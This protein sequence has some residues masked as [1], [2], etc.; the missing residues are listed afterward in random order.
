MIIDSH[1]HI[2]PSKIAQK[3]SDNIGRFYDI[4][5]DFDG[6]VEALIK[7]HDKAGISKAIVQ[8]VAT[9][10][11]QVCAINDFITSQVKEHSDRLIGFMTLHPDYEDIFGEVERATKAGL[12]GI[13]LHP[14]FQLFALNDKKAYPIYE[15][16]VAMD[17]P[18]LIHAGD[19]RYKFSNP[20]L[21]REV[22]DNFPRLKMIAAHFGG[23]GEWDI[24]ADYLGDKEVWIDTSSSLYSISKE[25]ALA[26]IDVFGADYTLF[27]TDYPMWEPC[28][29]IKRVEALGLDNE[30]MEKIYHKNI[31]NLLH[32]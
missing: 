9:S 15:A 28:E 19:P 6:T 18:V 30:T 2:F 7:A 20:V 27:G 5:M 26:L 1:A 25:K 4:P 14:D 23:W 3:A 13:K 11:L 24:S 22:L 8:S 32:L 12:L 10:P 16:A 29:E 31:E 21:I 17:L